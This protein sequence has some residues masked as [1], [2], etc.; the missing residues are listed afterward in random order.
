VHFHHYLASMLRSFPN[1]YYFREFI[2]YFTPGF[3]MFIEPRYF[4]QYND[5]LRREWPGF[6]SGTINVLFTF[7]S[8]SALRF[9]QPSI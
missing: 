5:S 8:I 2:P 6:D 3:S 4:H 7:V 9:I 1:F